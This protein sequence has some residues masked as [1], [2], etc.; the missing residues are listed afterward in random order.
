MM[1]IY[2][3]TNANNNWVSSIYLPIALFTML[4]PLALITIIKYTKIN[5]FLKTG[6][7]ILSGLIIT[8]GSPYFV[9]YVLQKNNID[10]E[11][12]FTFPP[13]FT[14]W[15]NADMISSNTVSIVISSILIVAIVFISLGLIKA[16]NSRKH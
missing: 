5:K 8:C 2:G 10:G 16:K 13:N 7:S 14:D 12:N 6:L 1:I 11:I 3:Y 9:F 4:L 15:S